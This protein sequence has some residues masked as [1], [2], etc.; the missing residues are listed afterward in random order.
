MQKT[1]LI[2]GH[3]GRFGRH[4]MAALKRHGWQTRP[5]NRATDTLQDAARGTQLIVNGWNPI[6]SDWAAQIP[7]L[8]AQVIAAAKTS[9]AAVMIPGNVYVF[10]EDIP[11]IIGPDTPHRATNPLG[12]IRRRMEAAYRDAGVK[13]V[14]LRAGD[15]IDTEASGNWFDMIIVA[16]LAKGRVTYPGPMDQPHSWAYL[17][18]LAEAGARLAEKL[19]D[20]PIFSDFMF[21]G[22]TLTGAELAQAVEAATGQRL[23]AKTMSWLP[24]HLARPFWAEAKHLVEMRYLWNQPHRADGTKL[25]QVIPNLCQTTVPDALAVACAPLS[26]AARDRLEHVHP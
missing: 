19:D 22:Y 11:A 10:G 26:P 20:L 23:K 3:T 5:F 7:G 16:K 9:G 13:A 12:Q 24:I 2:L 8:T 1:A 4:M 21:D 25:A 18:N 15:Y 17:P 6:Y 14:I